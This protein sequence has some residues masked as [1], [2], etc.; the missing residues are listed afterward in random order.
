MGDCHLG[1]NVWDVPK[2]LAM[3][4]VKRISNE[5]LALEVNSRKSK[6]VIESK[7][8]YSPHSRLENQCLTYPSSCWRD[9]N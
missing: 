6:R 4:T 8:S 2:F 1:D 9:E 3:D 7:D 5:S